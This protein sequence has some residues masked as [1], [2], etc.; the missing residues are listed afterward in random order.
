MPRGIAPAKVADYERPKD[1]NDALS[2]L[3]AIPM[4]QAGFPIRLFS[5]NR[6]VTGEFWYEAS[7]VI[8]MLDRFDM[9]L[10][11]PSWPVNMW[12]GAMLRLFRPQIEE[13]L[14]ARDRAV[15][16]WQAAHPGENTFEDRGLEITSIMDISVAG[17]IKKVNKALKAKNA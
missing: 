1:A 2:H 4:N 7:D 10:A 17:Q 6:W 16:D 14:H 15:R 11:L 5:T 9:D 3:I 13:L 12:V 8:K